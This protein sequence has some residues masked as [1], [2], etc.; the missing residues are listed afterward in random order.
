M[1][2]KFLT[3]GAF[4]LMM[5]STASAETTLRFGTW[6]PETTHPT[7][8][9]KAWMESLQDASGGEIKVDLYPS[10]QL[11]NPRDHYN[12]ARD[13][14]ADLT[15][16]V[17]AFEPGRFPIFAAMEMPFMT[18]DAAKASGV[19]HEWYAQ[20][21]D[22]EMSETKFCFVTMAPNGKLSF[23]D[24]EVV[25]YAEIAGLRMRPAGTLVTKYFTDAGAVPVAIPAPEAQQAFDRGMLDGI[26]FPT[27]TLIPF[28][29]DR[30]VFYHQ[31]MIFYA[32]PAAVVFNKRS[33]DRLSE[34]GRAAVDAHCTPEWS[35]RINGMWS[36]WEA[37][38]NQ[39]LAESDDRH[40]FFDIPAEAQAE[41]IAASLPIRDAW[42]AD[43]ADD[44]DDP[45]AALDQLL[46]ALA[47][48]GVAY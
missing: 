41:W 28:G 34:Q 12:M 15:W 45:Q 43:V 36:D 37:E 19:F 46:D 7:P 35:E 47:Q 25:H 13:G 32:V 42:M 4:A 14:I 1:L 6:V 9:F 20:Y 11:G 39:I 2:T 18:T 22:E 8:G 24:R 40:V 30:S 29:M 5:T 3:A 26:A 17:P 23:K 38:A 31:Q 48:A 27:R 16:A 21:A 33:Y 10:G 44:L